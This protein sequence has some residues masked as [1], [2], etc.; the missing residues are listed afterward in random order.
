M[1][2]L[3]YLTP[4]IVLLMA[5]GGGGGG[6]KAPVLNPPSSVS[7]SADS[8]FGSFTLTWTEPATV[9]D[10]YEVEVKIGTG[11]YEKVGTTTIPNGVKTLKVYNSGNLAE[12]TPL[13]FRMRSLAGGSYSSYSNEASTKLPL[14]PTSYVSVYYDSTLGSMR[15]SW[16][17]D[18]LLA[19]T[20]KV[21]KATM[22]LSQPGPFATLF[23]GP[24]SVLQASD[25]NLKEDTTYRYR[26]SLSGQGETSK[27]QTADSIP[28]T[29][30][31]PKITSA[32]AGANGVTIQWQGMSA[33][34]SE[35]QIQRGT[36]YYSPYY[37]T[38]AGVPNGTTQFIDPGVVGG[39]YSYRL[40]VKSGF[41]TEYSAP[42][43]LVTLPTG[44]GLSL[45]TKLITLPSNI[46]AIGNWNGSP[47]FVVQGTV[48]YS[49]IIQPP[50]NAA[51]T[52]HTIYNIAEVGESGFI[53]DAQ[54]RPHLL[55]RRSLGGS[56]GVQAVIHEW[57]NGTS[58]TTE[59]LFRSTFYDSSASSG[60]RFAMAPDGF[61]H[62]VWQ[63]SDFSGPIWYGTNRSGT[64]ESIQLIP[65]GGISN[66]GTLRIAV[67]FDGTAYVAM[68]L[69][70][71]VVLFTR[72]TGITDFSQ[73]EV[74]TGTIRAGWYDSIEIQPFGAQLAF[75][76]ERDWTSGA[77][78][79]YPQMCVIKDQGSWNQP[80][81]LISRPHTGSSTV[82]KA[83]ALS[84]GR[85]AYAINMPDGLRIFTLGSN[86]TWNA[87]MLAPV[88]NYSPIQMGFNTQDKFWCAVDGGWGAQNGTEIY[89]WYSE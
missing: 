77:D 10:G 29:L 31:A 12:L 83:V 16:S 39:F 48:S 73:E 61:L 7:A 56:T 5:C 53:L 72:P 18:S 88:S 68:G 27:F 51:W 26:V 44:T 63:P 14:K 47:T 3:T 79:S 15:L 42:V 62:A 33:K 49:Y 13:A 17:N 21:E 78:L 25:D 38:I 75:F 66:L 24:A 69:W 23:E 34:A 85:L 84:N 8:T 37:V 2:P 28:I 60:I 70:N 82:A 65:V 43:N 67:G 52:A 55:F 36:G 71:K 1:R 32:I 64:W 19:T 40:A 81:Q 11:T 41:Q 20:V 6:P 45:A 59:E 74:P 54:G 46:M 50:A 89:A 4:L 76:Y 87:L 22:T 9:V 86:Q 57:F 80:T 30:L 35:V 58:W